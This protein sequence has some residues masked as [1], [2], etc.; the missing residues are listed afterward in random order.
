MILEG[1]TEPEL[2]PCSALAFK[3]ICIECSS[4]LSN[5]AEQLIPHCQVGVVRGTAILNVIW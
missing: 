3:D 5:V 4:Q 2:A 1:L